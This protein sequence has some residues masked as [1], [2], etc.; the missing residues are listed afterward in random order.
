VSGLLDQ[1][2]AIG[3]DVLAPAADAVDREARFPE[4][5]IAALRGAGMLGL[6]VP[7]QLGGEGVAVGGVVG[8]C[9][10]LGQYCANTAMVYAMH[11]IQLACLVLHA[12]GAPWPRAFLQ[13]AAFEQLLIASATTEAETGGDVTRSACALEWRGER[14]GV[15]KRG[16]VI[17][18][19]AQADA[20]LLTA[21]RNPDAA[22]TDQSLVLLA[23][24]D[25]ALEVSDEW[26][27]LGMRGTCSRTYTLIG[28]G[29]AE[30][31]LPLPYAE[32]SAYTMLPVSHL[33]WAAVWAGIAAGAVARAQ[34]YSRAQAR[35]KP[36]A[37]PAGAT[38]LADAVGL[39]QQ[40][41]AL[42]TCAAQRYE[43]ARHHQDDLRSFAFAIEMNTLKTTVSE[44]AV[45]AVQQALMVCGLSGYRNDSPYSVA[46]HLRDAH[47]AAL[48]VNNDRITANTAQMLLV[49]K[50]QTEL[51]L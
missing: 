6:L 19:G 22:A 8:I 32:L 15:V 33:V 31:V 42:V 39:L 2:H 4:E 48:M 9:H 20:V 51:V 25:Y 10:A 41:H 1:I 3:R 46:R 24:G 23:R 13:R 34:A 50:T 36:G 26:N 44:A 14:F 27:A 17:S 37:V 16:T 28:G 47:S 30:Q 43:A 12:Q 11:Q 21:R 7:T 35:K 45:R 5:G 29:Q 49:Q 38:R 18:Y 40:M